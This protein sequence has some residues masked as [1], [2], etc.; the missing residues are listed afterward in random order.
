[1]GFAGGNVL[2]MPKL[3]R[4]RRPADQTNAL[5]WLA[6]VAVVVVVL[7]LLVGSIH[8]I[9]KES[10]GYRAAIDRSF[11][12]LATPVVTASNLTSVDLSN[13]L[14]AVGTLPNNVP[15]DT[16]RS[17]LQQGLDQAVAATAQQSSQASTM[18]NPPASD[19]LSSHFEQVMEE[20]ASAVSA[21]RTT[22]DQLLGMTPVPIAGSPPTTAANAPVSIALTG[23]QASAQ[24]AEEGQRLVS[25]DATYRSLRGSA[26]H[27]STPVHLPRSVWV[28]TPAA[29]APLGPNLLAQTGELLATSTNMEPVRRLII[30]AVGLAPPATVLGGVGVAATSCVQ[31]QLTTPTST[32]TLLPPTKTLGVAVTVTNCGN[33]PEAGVVVGIILALADP[34]GIRPP[35]ARVQGGS[36]SRSLTRVSGGSEAVTFPHLSVAA[37]H[38]Y[39]LA[40]SI[41]SSPAEAVASGAADRFLIHI[42]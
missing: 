28:A 35:G 21:M 23:S 37:G 3:R 41:G 12:A 17:R 9:N 22:I 14:Q 26:A 33:V 13:L 19:N 16:A 5:R 31:P 27:L 36:G 15:P 25:A 39:S 34:V 40:V 32:P 6:V 29:S 42:A 2:A 1:M 10:S 7:V 20:R 8:S 11:A 30:T 24:L 38:T 4:K 18:A